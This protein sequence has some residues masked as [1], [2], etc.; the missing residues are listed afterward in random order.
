MINEL[1]VFLHFPS[2][3]NTAEVRHI[4]LNNGLYLEENFKNCVSF[5]ICFYKILN[6]VLKIPH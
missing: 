6:M 5:E 4:M 2:Y 1:F 3:N